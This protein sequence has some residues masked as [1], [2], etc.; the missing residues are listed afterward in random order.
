MHAVW[1]GRG[2]LNMSADKTQGYQNLTKTHTL[3]FTAP[4]LVA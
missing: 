4:G 1:D 2:A 3:A